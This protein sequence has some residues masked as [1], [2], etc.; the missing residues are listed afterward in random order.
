MKFKAFH[1]IILV[2]GI[3]SVSCQKEQETATF[4]AQEKRI[5]TFVT[6]QL[7]ADTSFRA[8]YK[9]GTTRLVV[10]KGSG[11]SLSASG[12]VS[13]YYAGYIFSSTTITASNLFST[14]YKTLADGAS[15]ALSDTTAFN[16]LT[17]NMKNTDFLEGL[18][19]ALPGV[20]GGEECYILF[21]GKYGYRKRQVG[22]IPANS[23][24]AYH[25][26]VESINNE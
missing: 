5:S 10:K 12:T 17:L 13:F 16:I 8:I 15:W 21:S 18:K 1:I 3:L 2:L 22:T 6:T 14:N 19:R 25:I 20:K 26:W 24:L 23:A 11:D 4:N 9:N 7:S